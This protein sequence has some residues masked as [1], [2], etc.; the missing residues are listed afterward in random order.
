MAWKKSQNGESESE[1][2]VC[3]IME[4][5]WHRKFPPALHTLPELL[6]GTFRH[7][8]SVTIPYPPVPEA[9]KER[10]DRI[11]NS[12]NSQLIQRG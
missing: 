3:K 9:G 12:P 8:E 11:Y 5:F 1:M 10:E 6:A 4:H 2:A 7:F